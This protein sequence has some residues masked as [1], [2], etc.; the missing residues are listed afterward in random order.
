MPK[1]RPPIS[2]EDAV[3]G[4][5]N[6]LLVGEPPDRASYTP[7]ARIEM[8]KNPIAE[9]ERQ[10]MVKYAGDDGSVAYY[11]CLDPDEANSVAAAVEGRLA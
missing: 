11:M 6:W 5:P 8:A 3:S 7:D 2:I 1:Y 10:L 9:Q 4:N